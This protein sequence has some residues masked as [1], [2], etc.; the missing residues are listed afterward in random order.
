M[1]VFSR[2]K[3]SMVELI[4]A[5]TLKVITS[6]NDTKH[7]MIMHVYISYPGLVIEDIEAQM[8]RM[9]DGECAPAQENIKKIIGLEIGT[10]LTRSVMERIGDEHGCTHLTDMV[11]E[12]AK[13]AIQSQY[14]LKYQN[15]EHQERKKAIKQDLKDNCVLFAER[16]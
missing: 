11:V 15:L 10:G 7:E 8:L 9:P 12:S 16:T 6:L 14:T 5:K 13:A 4:D 3:S 1:F 2:H